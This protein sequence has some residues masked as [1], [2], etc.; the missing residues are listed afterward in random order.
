MIARAPTRRL[1]FKLS[2]S[3]AQLLLDVTVLPDAWPTRLRMSLTA[4]LPWQ[5]DGQ[6][7]RSCGCVRLAAPYQLTYSPPLVALVERSDLC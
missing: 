6:Q 2:R 1:A 4:R 3:L 5:K 7:M